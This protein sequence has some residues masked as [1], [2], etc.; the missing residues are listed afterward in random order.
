M[1][2]TEEDRLRRL[3]AELTAQLAADTD[4]SIQPQSTA[5]T[6]PDAAHGPV[7]DVRFLY[8]DNLNVKITL[9]AAKAS[10]E[11]DTRVQG[12]AKLDLSDGY[13]VGGF[14]GSPSVEGEPHHQSFGK[15]RE[16]AA[17]IIRIA[18]EGVK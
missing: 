8:Q 1:A 13:T 5:F 2:P 9:Q 11:G 3:W 7:G 18:R 10:L 17:E 6:G 4:Y 15:A 12:E 16:A 14:D